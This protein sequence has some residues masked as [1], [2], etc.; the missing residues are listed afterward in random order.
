MKRTAAVSLFTLTIFL[1][2][3]VVAQAPTSGTLPTGEALLAK[4]VAATGGGAAHE[5]IKSR[6]VHAKMEI[7]DAG[8]T[9]SVTVYQARPDRIVTVA[10]SDAIGRIESGVVDGVAWEKS[11]M[12]GARIK[13]GQERDDAIRDATFDRLV[14]WKKFNKRVECVGLETV[15]G[16]QCFKVVVT[17]TVGSAQTIYLD[18]ESALIVKSESSIDA[19]EGKFQVVSIP[20]DYRQVDDIKM[21]FSS[22]VFVAGQTRI[23][24]TERVEHNVE[25]PA[26]RLA[27]PAEI[28]ALVS[29]KQK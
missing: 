13:V 24:T 10:E 21:P 14:A 4:Y 15:E 28:K 19:P 12:R 22:K 6:V 9:F 25:I 23:V 2:G 27:L 17:P 8:V 5:A 1:A 7:V 16:K 11:A 26:D 3:P 29:A 20:S 18:P